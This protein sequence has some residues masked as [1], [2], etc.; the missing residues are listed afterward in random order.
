MLPPLSAAILASFPDAILIANGGGSWIDA[1]PA[2]LSL[3]GHKH[4]ALLRLG[5]TDIMAPGPAWTG[6]AQARLLWEGRWQ[7]DVSVRVKDGRLV[8]VE[9]RAIK[10]RG[11]E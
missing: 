2:A 9:A 7:G 10:I 11:P 1:N 6:E 3:L 8:P 5:V 4:A